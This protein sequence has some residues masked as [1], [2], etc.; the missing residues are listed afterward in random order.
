MD[1]ETSI[2]LQD[3]LTPGIA[4]TPKLVLIQVL[5]MT[6]PATDINL[7]SGACS[8]ACYPCWFVYT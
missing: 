5:T 4:L 1:E 3:H 7:D 6:R 2:R 8:G